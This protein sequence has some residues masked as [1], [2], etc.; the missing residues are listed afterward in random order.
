MAFFK[1]DNVKKVLLY[2]QV[3]CKL[4]KIRYVEV[5]SSFTEYMLFETI[6]MHQSMLHTC[7]SNDCEMVVIACTH[8][9]TLVHKKTSL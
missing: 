2:D 5:F 4:T 3:F 9:N 7:D 8:I 6:E 1:V